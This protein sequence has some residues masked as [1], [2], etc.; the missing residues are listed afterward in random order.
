MRSRL[1]VLFLNANG[2]EIVF[3]QVAQQLRTNLSS[4]LPVNQIRILKVYYSSSLRIY[5]SCFLL[6]NAKMTTVMMQMKKK[7]YS[8]YYKIARVSTCTKKR[9]TN[10][11]S[12][13]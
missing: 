5:P 2:L 6:I 9:R 7:R 13:Q 11:N 1:G 8:K 12:H 10:L 4:H 3:T